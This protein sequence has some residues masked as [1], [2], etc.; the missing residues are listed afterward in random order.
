MRKWARVEE[1]VT[2]FPT[3]KFFQFGSEL[4]Q[5]IGT[6]EQRMKQLIMQHGKEAKDI[7][8]KKI[9]NLTSTQGERARERECF[10]YRL[11]SC[12]PHTSIL[13]RMT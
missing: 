9:K 10:K 3:F 7:S 6:N 2:Q 11:K 4:L 8:T 13:S 1:N 5:T 12:E